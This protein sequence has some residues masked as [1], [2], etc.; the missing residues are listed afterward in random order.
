MTVTKDNVV[1]ALGCDVSN[2]QGRTLDCHA[3]K[4]EGID[5][6][7]AK[8]TQG[9]SFNDRFFSLNRQAARAAALPFAAYHFLERGAGAQQATHFVN[10]VH[11]SGG[12]AGIGAVVDVELQQENPPMGPGLQ[13]V[14]DFVA[15]F[16]QL[17]PEKRLLLYTGGWYWRGYLGNTTELGDLALWDSSY[18]TGAGSAADL[19]QRG[20][21]DGKGVTPGFFRSYGGWRRHTIRQ[22]SSNATVAGI[23]PVDVDVIEGE[24]E[25]VERVFDLQA[26]LP[27]PP[28]PPLHSFTELAVDGSLG[29]A[30]VDALQ[31]WLRVGRDGVCGPQ[32]TAALQRR[33]GALPDGQWGPNTTRALQ[34]FLQGHGSPGVVVDGVL[35]PVTVSAL[36]RFLNAEAGY[37]H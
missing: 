7:V 11:G 14:K 9:V 31:W 32:T 16:R 6:V 21:G 1:L 29:R 25:A 28:P 23:Y 5:F 26:Q 12:F 30:T 35:G 36:Q 4:R 18:I 37:G 13:D 33:V 34:G 2:L 20:G 3:A 27:P 15:A 17:V 10:Y 22:Y 19:V 8:A 24:L